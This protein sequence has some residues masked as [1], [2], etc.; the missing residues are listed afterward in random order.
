MERYGVVK[1]E[2]IEDVERGRDKEK[3]EES[4]KRNSGRKGRDM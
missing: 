2:E 4:R 1:D 3:G